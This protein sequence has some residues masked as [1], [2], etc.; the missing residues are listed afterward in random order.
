MCAAHY[1]TASSLNQPRSLTIRLL[2]SSLMN[3]SSFAEQL[4]NKTILHSNVIKTLSD[5]FLQKRIKKE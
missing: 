3:D 1:A 2:I 4:H 5:S